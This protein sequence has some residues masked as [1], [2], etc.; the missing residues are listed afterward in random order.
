MTD[1][2]KKNLFLKLFVYHTAILKGGGFVG[3]GFCLSILHDSSF[4]TN[5][6]TIFPEL[7]TT[8]QRMLV[9][10]IIHSNA[11]ETVLIFFSIISE[12]HL[13][14]QNLKAS[15][16]IRTNKTEFHPVPSIHSFIFFHYIQCNTLSS[17]ATHCV[18]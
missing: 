10:V 1:I 6:T 3:F 4:F 15:D 8:W 5:T 18:F 11:F 7:W 12:R 2:I 13:F 17:P 16:K 9:F 14:L